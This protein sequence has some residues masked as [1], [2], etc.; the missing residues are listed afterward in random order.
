MR[1]NKGR[2][3]EFL[4]R[5]IADTL[6]VAKGRYGSKTKKEFFGACKWLNGRI[7]KPGSF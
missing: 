6:I 7:K 1:A 5:G 4:S 3:R 2:H